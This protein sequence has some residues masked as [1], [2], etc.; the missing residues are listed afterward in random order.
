MIYLLSYW[1]LAADWMDAYTGSQTDTTRSSPPSS[2]GLCGGGLLPLRASGCL[3]GLRRGTGGLSPPA[4]QSQ[5][6]EA[7]HPLPPAPLVPQ[8]LPEPQ[9]SVRP[10]RMVV[11]PHLLA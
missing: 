1:P 6:H 5:Q 2:C 7:E 4:V 9:P 11:R 3:I 8:L 10:L